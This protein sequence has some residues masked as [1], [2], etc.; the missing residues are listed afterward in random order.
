MKIWNPKRYHDRFQTCDKKQPLR[1]N[2]NLNFQTLKDMTSTP[3]ILPYKKPPPLPRGNTFLANLRSSI[4]KLFLRSMPPKPP[5]KSERNFLAAGR[6]HVFWSDSETSAKKPQY[7]TVLKLPYINFL[8]MKI[9]YDR[10]QL[11]DTLNK[12]LTDAMAI[13]LQRMKKN[14]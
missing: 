11:Q 5:R 10:F 13:K 12:A 8:T 6:L 9:F 1:D 7:A 3:T 2:Q 4:F 14:F